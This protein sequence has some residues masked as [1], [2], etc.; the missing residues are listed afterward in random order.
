MKMRLF[1]L[2]AAA[3][4]LTAVAPPSLAMYHPTMG[5]FMQ[6]DPI[7]TP[8]VASAFLARDPMPTR[9]QPELQYADGMN[10]Y[11]YELSNPAAYVDPLGLEALVKNH[12][13]PLHLGG[14]MDQ[15]LIEMPRANHGAIHKFFLSHGYGPGDAG[16]EAWSA[17]TS[18][19]QKTFVMRSLRHGGVSNGAVRDALSDVMRG[20]KPGQKIARTGSLG[21]ILR[22][23]NAK[24]IGIGTVGSAA[25]IVLTTT[26]PA[27][28]AESDPSWRAGRNGECKCECADFVQTVIYPSWW[29]Y[30]SD[31]EYQGLQRVSSW[32]DYGDLDTRKCADLESHLGSEEAG[33]ALGYT[34]HREY[35]SICRWDGRLEHPMA[36]GGN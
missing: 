28:A 9:P 34:I 12:P 5:R 16:R 31:V 14:R 13:Y 27:Y 33:S 8:I 17:L 20:A 29:N 1:A 32:V 21:R 15:W 18:R 36:E 22:P 23:G 35:F 30:A 24:V 7:G 26:K 11:Q 25:L 2:V 19:Q 3:F 6:R 4:A 10:L